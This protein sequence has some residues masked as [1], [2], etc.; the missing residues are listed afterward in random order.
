MK[1]I[2]KVSYH[3]EVSA[4]TTDRPEKIRIRFAAGFYLFA[5]DKD[6]LRR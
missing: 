3:T 1:P 4:S 5:I 2:L 6:N